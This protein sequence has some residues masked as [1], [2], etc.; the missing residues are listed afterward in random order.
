MKVAV[1]GDT[2]K[3]WSNRALLLDFAL[4]LQRYRPDRIVQV[5]DYL[6]QYS[7]SRYDKDPDAPCAQGEWDAAKL[8]SQ[9]FVNRITVAAPDAEV[10]II[11][12]NHDKR[13][14]QKVLQ[15]NL[16]ADLVRRIPEALG[17][18]E[19]YGWTWHDGSVPLVIDGVRYLHGDEVEGSPRQVAHQVGGPVVFGHQHTKAA[20]EYSTGYGR[21]LWGMNVG[22]AIDPSAICQRYSR[23]AIPKACL[24]WGTVTHGIPHWYPWE[25]VRKK[26]K[27]NR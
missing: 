10:D 4:F 11:E 6:D 14:K 16:P 27:K 22:C 7:W 15:A 17:I 3:P 13:I 5:G 2:H 9:W 8:E 19:G 23:K 20:I 18:P 21:V 25:L 12:G 26:P 24:G 1:L